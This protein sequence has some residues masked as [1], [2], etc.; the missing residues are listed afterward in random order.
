MEHMLKS[1]AGP[2]VEAEAHSSSSAKGLE[3]DVARVPV[4][5]FKCTV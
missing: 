4:A 1:P 5:V 3:V 2:T